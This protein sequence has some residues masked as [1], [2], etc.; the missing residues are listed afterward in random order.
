[1][2]NHHLPPQAEGGSVNHIFNSICTWCLQEVLASHP[3]PCDQ[4][5]MKCMK[6]KKTGHKMAGASSRNLFL[7]FSGPS[8]SKDQGSTSPTCSLAKDWGSASRTCKRVR[9]VQAMVV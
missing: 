6:C 4:P 1:M 8:L 5:V 2:A 9:A 7:R 3:I